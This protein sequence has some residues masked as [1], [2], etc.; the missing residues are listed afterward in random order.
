MINITSGLIIGKTAI[1]LQKIICV[2]ISTKEN[3][4]V[5]NTVTEAVDIVISINRQSTL[6]IR[7]F[8][9]IRKDKQANT[10]SDEK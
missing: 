5:E 3:I 6:Q 4:L 9:G 7:K 2:T 8:A 10:C 1:G